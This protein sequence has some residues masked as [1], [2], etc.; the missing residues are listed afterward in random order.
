MDRLLEQG[1]RVTI[2]MEPA[3]PGQKK[4]R[5]TIVSPITPKL[6]NSMYWGYTV[7]LAKNFSEV[8]SACPYGKKYDLIVGTSD[9]GKSV[10]EMKPRPFKHVLVIFG[11]L[12]GLEAVVEADETLT[13]SESSKLFNIYLNTC[14]TQGSRTIRTEEAI[15]ISLA[16]LQAKLT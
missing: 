14:P 3:K 8:F 9:K 6:E 15:L 10:D 5:G 7:R 1:V 11:G 13:A 4:M 2:K 16:A 12:Q